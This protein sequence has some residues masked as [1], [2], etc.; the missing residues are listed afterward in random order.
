[1][2]RN[3]DEQ[4]LEY[5]KRHHAYERWRD[6]TSLDENLF[7]WKFFLGGNELPGW[8]VVRIQPN[9]K[10]AWSPSIES[11]W[12]RNDEG[13]EELLNLNIFQCPSRMAAHE[14]LLQLL[15]DFQST[16]VA[17]KE[18]IEV[19]DVAF[20]GPEDTFLLFT[21]ANLVLLMRNA[22]RELISITEIARHFDRD[23]VSKPETMEVKVAPEIR[24]FY[25]PAIK[26]Q[27]G[28]NVPLEVEAF[29]PLKRPL[30][31]K[32]FSRFGEVL[33]EEGRLVYRP[34]IAGSQ[35]VILFAI[36]ANRGSAS[37]V[38]HLVVE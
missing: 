28:V 14:F 5:L 3:M 27:V 26:F 12:Q 29:D 22:G 16:R 21:R 13:G 17:R 25:S 7:I 1:M 38:L 32:F 36:N 37:Q 18:Q 19:G 8:H 33:L 2:V 23:L 31:Y 24:R 15:S 30:W 10:A 9:E 34:T 20:G 6:S 11:M 35:E 4:L